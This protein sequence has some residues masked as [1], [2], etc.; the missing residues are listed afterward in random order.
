M[1]NPPPNMSN[2][3]IINQA[4]TEAANLASLMEEIKN[5][6]SVVPSVASVAPSAPEPVAAPSAAVA[7][8]PSVPAFKSDPNIKFQSSNPGRNR[9]TLSYPRII[10]LLNKLKSSNE[11]KAN[12]VLSELTAATT[13]PEVQ[14]IINKNQLNLYNNEVTGGTKKRR[15]NKNKRTKRKKARHSR[16]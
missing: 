11:V 6:Q 7:T 4:A 1:Y 13:V 3:S 10:M 2:I 14:S 8:V 5:M 12:T 16:R 9:V 15:M